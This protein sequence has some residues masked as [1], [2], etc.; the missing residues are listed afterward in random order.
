MANLA[1]DQRG[2]L[3]PSVRGRAAAIL[4]RQALETTID[5]AWHRAG[6]QPNWSMRARLLC[7]PQ[8]TVE[9]TAEDVAD[10]WGFLSDACHH[11]P[12]AVGP[13]HDELAHAAKRLQRV[14]LLLDPS[15]N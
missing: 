3:P 11:H 6:Y 12:Y 2:A 10:L 1:L 13:T 7:L 8:I 5:A 9:E 14:A 4:L 15:A